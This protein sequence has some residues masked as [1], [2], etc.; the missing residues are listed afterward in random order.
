MCSY[1]ETHLVLRSVHNADTIPV[2]EKSKEGG[3]DGWDVLTQVTEILLDGMGTRS[4]V[5]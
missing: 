2:G 1:P 5:T 3:S 4:Q